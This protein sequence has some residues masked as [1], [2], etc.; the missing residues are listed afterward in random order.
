MANNTKIFKNIDDVVESYLDEGYSSLNTEKQK[1]S[2]LANFQ[3]DSTTT[4]EFIA[5]V[6]GYDDNY[7]FKNI[8]P[9]NHISFPY[10]LILGMGDKSNK[11]PEVSAIFLKTFLRVLNT[12]DFNQSLIKYLNT[13]Q[14]IG[15]I[16]YP[17]SLY[18]G[19]LRY[20]NNNEP[21]I[22][23]VNKLF[24]KTNGVNDI[25]GKGEVYSLGDLKKT[26]SYT[27]PNDKKLQIYIPSHLKI[28][29]RSIYNTST[30]LYDYQDDT[31]IKNG[32]ITHLTKYGSKYST[33]SPLVGYGIQNNFINEYNKFL[34][35]KSLNGLETITGT[36]V[37]TA[38][39]CDLGVIKPLK[40]YDGE[41]E[42]TAYYRN[43]TVGL[44]YDLRLDVLVSDFRNALTKINKTNFSKTD[45]T[46][47]YPELNKPLIDLF[48]IYS[49]LKIGYLNGSI[50]NDILKKLINDLCSVDLLDNN[51]QQTSNQKDYNDFYYII[52]FV[53][54]SSFKN[55]P[56]L[57]DDNNKL[58]LNPIY[59]SVYQRFNK[60]AKLKINF[61][62][63]A[64]MSLPIELQ[65]KLFQINEKQEVNLFNFFTELWVKERNN[66]ETKYTGL[67]NK[68]TF[69]LYPSAGGIFYPD[70]LMQNTKDSILIH[71]FNV[72]NFNPSALNINTFS[73]KSDYAPGKFWNLKKMYDLP[74]SAQIS[75]TSKKI[76]ITN[77]LELLSKSYLNTTY[78]QDRTTSQYFLPF[79]LDPN[80]NIDTSEDGYQKILDL[81]FDNDSILKNSNRLLWFDPAYFGGNLTGLRYIN[82]GYTE[83]NLSDSIQFRDEL[84]PLEYLLSENIYF[85]NLDLSL[86]RSIIDNNFDPRPDKLF[87]NINNSS[88]KEVN[89]DKL[90]IDAYLNQH[91]YS[92][93]LDSVSFDKL[94][95]FS[96]LFQD[97]SDINKKPD[98]GL[99]NIKSLIMACTFL[100][101][102]EIRTIINN[103][104]TYNS[105]DIS[106]MLIGNHTYNYDFIASSGISK[107]LNSSLTLTQHSR[108]K[109]VINE[110]LSTSTQVL[111]FTEFGT[112]ESKDSTYFNT[113]HNILTMP[114]IFFSNVT[115]FGEY[116]EKINTNRPSNIPEISSSDLGKYIFRKTY[117]GDKV[118]PNFSINYDKIEIHDAINKLITDSNLIVN[119]EL[120]IQDIF[121][122]IVEQFFKEVNVEISINTIEY[123]IKP[124]RAY[125]VKVLEENDLLDS[126]YLYGNPL[127][128]YK[129]IVTDFDK[130]LADQLT[131]EEIN[132]RKARLEAEALRRTSRLNQIL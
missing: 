80:Y 45:F 93:I 90:K 119:K 32:K 96:Q 98:D 100:T 92:R 50:T 110:F 51:T 115:N 120:N 79:T 58:E 82:N 106:M 15:N 41:I 30:I 128:F 31:E 112:V 84:D 5:S 94:D 95:Y 1:D 33:S 54:F 77:T 109:E 53:L 126:K 52:V 91:K 111:N 28:L 40:T 9:V 27:Y 107:I 23:D 18:L 88:K 97:F 116:L 29:N 68:S 21:K 78:I 38:V 2:G 125:I 46:I 8:P 34:F 122:Q 26:I 36:D 71:D 76:Y 35:N 48:L 73:P 19:S 7:L 121:I 131:I 108:V 61:N 67:S 124:I 114:E 60:W 20:F 85:K 14:T 13:A 102:D 70:M 81:S 43:L 39:G 16:P 118:V 22:Y 57:V 42:F 49:R 129:D 127:I 17:I 86:N 47:A 72:S 104:I 59:K 103:K 105:I 123:L 56:N 132:K 6:N 10:Y 99:Y 101:S 69:A 113:A 83:A 44:G 130:K 117:F 65:K 74:N 62:E 24:S 66:L 75:F 3:F 12:P 63:L 37:Y 87:V 89:N 4:N 55:N 11:L 25:S 64:E